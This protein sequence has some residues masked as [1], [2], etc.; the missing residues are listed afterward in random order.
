[1]NT[2]SPVDCEHASIE[3]HIVRR[4]SSQ[5]VAGIE[6]LAGCAVLPRLDMPGQEHPGAA[7]RCGPQPAKHTL[8]PAIGQDLAGEHVLADP[9]RRQ[10]DPL[11]LQLRPHACATVLADLVAQGR[12]EHG[13]VEFLLAERASSPPCSR[14]RKSGN[15]AGPMVSARAACSR[16]R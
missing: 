3:G 14:P 9:D 16:T 15:R 1:M 13:N 7:E 5:A 8:A 11:G 6:A 2:Q 10:E 12:F 4:T